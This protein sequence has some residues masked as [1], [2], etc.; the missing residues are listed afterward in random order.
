MNHDRAGNAY[1][2]PAKAATNAQRG[3]YGRDVAGGGTVNRFSAQTRKAA[4][5][6]NQEYNSSIAK[7]VAP[8]AAKG[9]KTQMQVTNDAGG[10]YGK[11][12]GDVKSNYKA[13]RKQGMSPDDARGSALGGANAKMT[14][15][16][17]GNQVR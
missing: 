11:T 5:L 10:G 1:G 7:G 15:D 17:Q 3:A 8:N 2:S 6:T 16:A 12:M 9:S 13:A 14:R 4:P